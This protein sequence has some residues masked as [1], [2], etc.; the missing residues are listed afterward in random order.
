MLLL[1]GKEEGDYGLDFSQLVLKRGS[2]LSNLALL[3]TGVLLAC[4]LGF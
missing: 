4:R 2:F 3:K 1:L